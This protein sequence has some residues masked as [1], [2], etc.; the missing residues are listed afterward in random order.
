[1]EVWHIW[2]MAALLFVIVEI[3]T[4]GFAV[5]CLSLGAAVAALISFFGYSVEWQLVFF[6]IFTA[7]AFILVRP[8]LY[9]K[10]LDYKV[11]RKSGIEALIGREA[12]VT[13]RI[14]GYGGRVSVDGDSWRAIT[15]GNTVIDVGVRACIREVRSTI[16][17]VEVIS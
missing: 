5:L 12:V 14:D 2:I 8:L 10:F 1:M 13:E 15:I 17:V 3:F 9:R 11:V 7:L 6:A 4:T 16:L